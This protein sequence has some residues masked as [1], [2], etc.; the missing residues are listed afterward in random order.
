MTLKPR[1][2]AHAFDF[3][4]AEQTTN[5]C[6]CSV[7]LNFLD[8]VRIDPGSQIY[9][10]NRE[11]RPTFIDLIKKNDAWCNAF[12]D[13]APL[14]M[15]HLRMLFLQN[16]AS[17]TVRS[18]RPVLLSVSICS[19]C[20]CV[21]WAGG[22]SWIELDLFLKSWKTWMSQSWRETSIDTGHVTHTM[23]SLSFV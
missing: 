22:R 15:M 21:E 5:D 20:N 18:H 1:P 19:V 11:N 8:R 7:I 14:R 23:R 13:W 9:I 2:S 3:L 6:A 10:S 4:Q 16:K 17:Y 12:W